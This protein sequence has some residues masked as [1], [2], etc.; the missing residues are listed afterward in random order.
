M[1]VVRLACLT[2]RFHWQAGPVQ[3]VMMVRIAW[4]APSL[5]RIQVPACTGFALLLDFHVALFCRNTQNRTHNTYATYVSIQMTVLINRWAAITS[6]C[7]WKGF[8]KSRLLFLFF[9]ASRSSIRASST[10]HLPRLSPVDSLHISPTSLFSPPSFPLHS[11]YIT[12]LL[13][14]VDIK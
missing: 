14:D 7:Q 12:R 5:S 13:Y 1:V 2:P 10:R 6:N 11:E 3:F 8:A 9:V 4:W